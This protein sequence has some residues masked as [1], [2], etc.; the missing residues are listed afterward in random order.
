MIRASAG[1]SRPVQLSLSRANHANNIVAINLIFNAYTNNTIASFHVQAVVPI[2]PVILVK[3]QNC[4]LPWDM[5]YVRYINTHSFI[6]SS[7]TSPHICEHLSDD[8]H[9]HIFKHL[10]GSEN[11]HPLC[12]E[13]RFTILDSASSYII[14]Q[15]SNW[16]F[17]WPCTSFGISRL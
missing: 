1:K 10:R 16:N 14:L 4:N 6:H 17:R 13:D 12:S 11:W 9:L 3:Q 7:D 5:W 8:K 2:V 15:A